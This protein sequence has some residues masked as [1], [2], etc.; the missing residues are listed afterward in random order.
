[1]RTRIL[2]LVLVAV[3]C[4]V[5]HAGDELSK[6]LKVVTTAESFS[7]SVQDN[8]GPPVEAKFQKDMPLSCKA[9]KVEF[10]RK[11]ELLVYKE[12]DN[13]QR[14]RTGTLSDPL[15]I[16]GPSAKVRA[17]RLPHEELATLGKSLAKIKKVDGVITGELGADAAKMLART[18]DRDLARGGNAKLWLDKDGKLTKYEISIR[19]QGRRGN[20]DVDGTTTRTVAIS[21][22][23][24]TKIELPAGAK[25]ALE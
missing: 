18:E 23:G 5:V 7:F 11:G 24:T 17:I 25:K 2:I 1:M 8:A 6:Q 3:S 12:R 21:A 16:L 19:I 20:A 9:D 15:R 4:G 14:T 22:V 13:W 10:F